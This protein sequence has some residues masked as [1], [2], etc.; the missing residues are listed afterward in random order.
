[1]TSVPD[2]GHERSTSEA[3]Q[4]WKDDLVS[5]LDAVKHFG[6]FAHEIRQSLFINPGLVVFDTPIPLPLVS[7]DAELIRSQCQ[8][9][10]LGRDD[11][12]AIDTGT[13]PSVLSADSFALTNPAW[14]QY[15]ESLLRTVSDKLGTGPLR[16]RLDKLS[17]HDT[18][19]VINH[20]EIS[21]NGPETIAMLEIRL[22]SAHEG[23]EVHVSHAEEQLLFDTSK[24]SAWNLSALAWFA[25]A[26]HEV[27]DVVSGHRLV[28]TYLLTT[29]TSHLRNGL[30]SAQSAIT[31]QKP[32]RE[33]FQEWQNKFTESARKLIYPLRQTYPG[34]RLSLEYLDE[35]DRAR[36]QSL[37]D[38][39][40]CLGYLLLGNMQISP[41]TYDVLPNLDGSQT[42][43]RPFHPARTCEGHEVDDMDQSDPAELLVSEDSIRRG[44]LINQEYVSVAIMVP[45]DRFIE[46]L[47]LGGL[48]HN[49]MTEIYAEL[50]ESHLEESNG[51]QA[52]LKHVQSVL[53]QLTKPRAHFPSTMELAGMLTAVLRVCR[54]YPHEELE[55]R[56]IQLAGSLVD[57]FGSSNDLSLALA[58]RL[59]SLTH[60]TEELWNITLDPLILGTQR[61]TLAGAFNVLE[62]LLDSE[63]RQQSF[64]TW[65]TSLERTLLFEEPNLSLS[66]W[67][68]VASI[69]RR[70]DCNWT[71]EQLG[72]LL[73]HAKNRSLV[74]AVLND[75]AREPMR[76]L[77]A[78][79]E[80]VEYL[81]GA[82]LDKLSLRNTDFD[83]SQKRV[84]SPSAYCA[85]FSRFLFSTV[86]GNG[87]GP[88]AEDL[89]RMSCTTLTIPTRLEVYQR[90]SVFNSPSSIE[91]LQ[92]FASRLWPHSSRL[93]YRQKLLVRTLLVKIICGCI[94]SKLP[95]RPRKPR[96]WAHPT[97]SPC[98]RGKDGCNPCSRLN[99]F[100]ESPDEQV[101]TYSDCAT[102]IL[103]LQKRLD[104]HMGY[105]QDVSRSSGRK[106]LLTVQKR[107][108]VCSE[109][110]S[111]VDSWTSKV[112]EFTKS[113]EIFQADGMRDI[114]GEELYE[115]LILLST[116]QNGG[117]HP[118]RN[119]WWEEDD[120]WLDDDQLIAQIRRTSVPASSHAEPSSEAAAN[121]KRAAE[122]GLENTARRQ[123]RIRRLS[124]LN[125]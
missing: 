72:P 51:D 79:Q 57:K 111:A 61:G 40:R 15:L 116:L 108:E 9:P 71:K 14:P 99:A 53:L 98:S 28:V 24:E 22:P 63:D 85:Q 25:D 59:N 54:L 112:Q 27:R 21:E 23:G 26:T 82:N 50:L 19:P 91:V 87:L 117:P 10:Q 58:A 1:M 106:M 44:A 52:V 76:P 3:F 121:R 62:S 104:G 55:R 33:S 29:K 4:L 7:R 6:V 66:D 30:N 80:V 41:V 118:L 67:K 18:G 60:T 107:E 124:R 102:N 90:A 47:G 101:W 93:P 38:A 70:S 5:K 88:E 65:R 92:H 125:L 13:R 49:G 17:L 12:I 119:R 114:L 75:L 74:L 95:G 64:Q 89:L 46:L 32:I 84:Q 77:S 113:M 105:K 110:W 35:T 78:N 69:V 103:H 100:L 73:N 81:I 8:R 42:L 115:E 16:A 86:D 45:Q 34:E 97:L 39:C 122:D 31:Q 96:P 48:G 43:Y 36:V 11:L 109:H 123:R 68:L 37:H 20:R 2:R 120:E 56:A 83:K 94:I